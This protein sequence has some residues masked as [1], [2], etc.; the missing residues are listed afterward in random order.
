M[1]ELGP[2]CLLVEKPM[3]LPT[4]VG[5]ARVFIDVETISHD[6][7]RGG[8]LPY[9]GDEI[10]GIG[11]AFNDDPEAYYIPVR[12]S[13]EGELFAPIFPM[14]DVDVVRGW[15]DL[16]LGNS[17]SEIVGH[18][19]IFDAHFFAQAGVDVQ[20]TLLDTLT[21][22]KIVD[23]QH[24]MRYGLK[25]LAADWL[26]SDNDDV[27]AVKNELHRMKTKDYGAVAVDVLALYCCYDIHKTRELYNEIQDRRYS[28][29]EK[30]WDLEVATT[31]SLFA[32]ERRG[33]EVDV[34]KLDAI[35]MEYAV[36][37]AEAENDAHELGF[38][39]VNMGS[40]K[41]L[42][43]FVLD[44][45]RLPAVEWSKHTGAPAI[46]SEAISIYLTHEEVDETMHHFF[47][48]L[49]SYREAKQWIGLYAEGWKEY[50]DSSSV[51][52]P[53][54]NQT[55]ST[56]RMSSNSPN[57]QQLNAKAKQC[58]V[59]RPGCC[60]LA[61][62]YSSME[63]RIIASISR[64]ERVIE[65]YADDPDTDFHTLIAELCNIP[66]K[67]AKN[68]NFG[69]A[70][71][72][73]KAGV[74]RQLRKS[75]D[76]PISEGAAEVIFDEYQN[77]FPAI[78]ATSREV[79]AIAAARAGRRDGGIGY[80][81]TLFGRKRALTYYSF[82]HEKRDQTRK[83]FNT[84]VQGTAADITKRA[85]CALEGDSFLRDSGVTVL[86]IVHDEFLFEIPESR[87]EDP[88]I[89][90]RIVA[91]MCNAADDKLSVPLRAE[92]GWS[93]DNWS[94]AK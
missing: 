1:Y 76:T 49:L 82:G 44:E 5:S 72:L 71:G 12:S 24:R 61:V 43:E 63:F 64:D 14:M 8:F 32:V 58:I 45:R 10:A 52:R 18:N 51:M 9:A 94:E 73:G 48:I 90:N 39:H 84:I 31:N 67:A 16:V 53:R 2:N 62:D 57:T 26:G 89:Q 88:Q 35:G 74:V 83:A 13:A 59:P 4:P 91:T 77:R 27:D 34:E 6:S 54:Y 92:G 11:V 30:I 23:G 19:I 87:F 20:G 33:M 69:L 46:G 80:I 47:E 22:A 78:K 36:Q 25:N 41:S 17:N 79:Q 15:L 60:L 70:F 66:R 42:R 37:L 65:A 50:I 81:K 55:V 75:F 93:P 40:P 85:L 29:D 3:E 7:T 21:L 56:G 68:M 86:A 28:G 38:G